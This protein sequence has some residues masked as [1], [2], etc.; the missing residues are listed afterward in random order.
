M[1]RKIKTDAV[2]E[3]LMEQCLDIRVKLSLL[4]DKQPSD[5]AATAALLR[6]LGS[7]ETRIR[8][9]KNIQ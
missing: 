1:Y 6:Q 7:L 9:R 8:N 4:M 2:H 3:A 5:E